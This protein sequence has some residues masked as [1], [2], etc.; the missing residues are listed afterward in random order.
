VEA[1]VSHVLPALAANG[2]DAV[3]RRG[4]AR[5][6]AAGGGAGRQRAAYAKRGRLRDVVATAVEITHEQATEDDDLVA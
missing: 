4:V 2:D 5:I 6:L 3:V 1:L